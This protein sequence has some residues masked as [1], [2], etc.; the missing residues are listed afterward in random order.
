MAGYP[1]GNAAVGFADN[2]HEDVERRSCAVDLDGRGR[3]VAVARGASAQ[4]SAPD[5]QVSCPTC[6]LPVESAINTICPS[7][8]EWLRDANN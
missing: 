4:S 3:V 5:G 6:S 1:D 8:A 7:V 2:V